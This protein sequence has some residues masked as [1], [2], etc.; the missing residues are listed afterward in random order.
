VN[1]ISGSPATTGWASDNY[2]TKIVSEKVFAL[3]YLKER[4]LGGC[5]GKLNVLNFLKYFC[6]TV[7]RFA[8][9]SS[10]HLA[11]IRI[12]NEIFS[13]TAHSAPAKRTEHFKLSKIVT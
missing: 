1:G 11:Q 5:Q 7:K 9:F 4:Y 2:K 13:N 3:N 8:Y 6:V 12:N 10:F